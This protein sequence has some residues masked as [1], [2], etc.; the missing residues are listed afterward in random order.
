M[1]ESRGEKEVLQLVKTNDSSVALFPIQATLMQS[2]QRMVTER[3]T[4]NE[5]K[6]VNK[7]ERSRE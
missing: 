5:V 3:E 2:Y 4:L 1:R 7:K 6:Q